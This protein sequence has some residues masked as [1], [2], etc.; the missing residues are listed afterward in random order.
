ME[1]DFK[2]YVHGVPMGQKI[3][4]AEAIDSNYIEMFYGRKFTI[5]THMLVETRNYASSAYCYY[6][7]MPTG[8]TH[9]INGRSGGYIALTLRFNC[10]Y[11]DIQNIYNL[12]EAAYN[13]FVVGTVVEVKGDVV[14]YIKDFSNADG[15]LRNLDQEIKRY[16]SQFSS[17]S[18]FI[19]LASFN[20]KVNREQLSLNVLD[21]RSVNVLDYVRKGYSISVSPL[22][23]CVREK[24]AI[25]TAQK[26]VATVKKDKE[27]A[28]AAVR[29]EYKNINN[30]IET[31]QNKLVAAQQEKVK[32][33]GTLKKQEEELGKCRNY[34]N[35]YET[36]VKEIDDKNA[37]LARVQTCM[38][39][40]SRVTS[41]TK[42]VNRI[43]D[44]GT[45]KGFSWIRFI[46]NI[47]PFL[48]FV[49]LVLA[50]VMMIIPF[51]GNKNDGGKDLEHDAKSSSS[52]G[53]NNVQET[54]DSSKL[55]DQYQ[56]AKIDVEGLNGD[57]EQNKQYKVT[58]KGVGDNLN[59]TWC[60]ED[61]DIDCEYY[62]TPKHAGKCIISYIVGK[63]T[64]RKREIDVK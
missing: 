34:K 11:A 22:Y 20:A 64:L 40:L 12:L 5:P 1:L 27:V 30:T 38:A 8:N 42:V 49:L 14:R 48:N 41:S 24:K 50:I 2:L 58:L 57:M 19:S 35:K 59:G 45:K 3:W 54:S 43:H 56:N 25:E 26:E 60:S 21:C 47:L 62:I 16:L 61:F 15:A 37:V 51:N 46:R 17:D 9:D 6:T 39:D 44:D 10:Y 23:I 33:G 53:G 29:N 63:D 13:K 28:V 32:L 4:G 18:D 7:Y 55:G 31:L 36:A 52:T